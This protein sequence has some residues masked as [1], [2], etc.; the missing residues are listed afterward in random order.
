[1]LETDLIGKYAQLVVGTYTN[2][3]KQNNIVESDYYYA[4]MK[5]TGIGTTSEGNKSLIGDLK[6]HSIDCS[7]DILKLCKEM[8]KKGEIDFDDF[9]I[10]DIDFELN[11]LN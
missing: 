3:D 2:F 8:M 9:N 10:L 1:M 5:I 11:E 4:F 6:F 7:E